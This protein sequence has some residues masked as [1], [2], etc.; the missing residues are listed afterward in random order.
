MRSV[1][2]A[3]IN[4]DP[5]FQVEDRA[6]DGVEA[7]R[8]LKTKMYD[9]VVLDVVLPRMSGTELVHE[10]RRQRNPIPVLMLTALTWDYP[11]VVKAPLFEVRL[12]AYQG[13]GDRRDT[14]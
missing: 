13:E 5:R 3:I 1:L 9:A 12:A 6:G 14:A 10:L 4:N 11:Q 2:G 8:L 7:L